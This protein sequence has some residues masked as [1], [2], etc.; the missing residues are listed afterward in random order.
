ME[1]WRS[2]RLATSFPPAVFHVLCMGPL[3]IFQGPSGLGCTYA[4]THLQSCTL[5]LSQC[6]DSVGASE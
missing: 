2:T 6:M 4:D 1:R 3:C 5:S